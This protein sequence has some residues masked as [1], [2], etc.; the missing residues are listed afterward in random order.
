[1]LVLATL[2]PTTLTLVL[3]LVPT[4][5]TLFTLANRSHTRESYY[6]LITYTFV[7]ACACACARAR[8]AASGGEAAVLHDAHYAEAAVIQGAV[9]A[10]GAARGSCRARL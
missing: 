3:T 10:S 4:T 7:R 5:L 6:A 1:M 9:L 8:G 2:V